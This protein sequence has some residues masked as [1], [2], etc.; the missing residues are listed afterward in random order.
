MNKQLSLI[1]FDD[2]SSSQI[3]KEN[4]KEKNTDEQNLQLH[5]SRKPFVIKTI[6]TK[7][8]DKEMAV[9]THAKKLSEYIFTITEKSPKK[10]RWSIVAKLQNTS[11]EVIENLYH[12]NFDI[13]NR[14][15]FQTKAN[16]KLHL[17]EHFAET[18]KNMQAINIHQML[19]MGK[20]IA[21]TQKL[22]SGWNRA[23]KEKSKQ[24]K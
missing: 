10:Y 14:E 5:T 1:K 3:V 17:L 19:V 23:T 22:L 6:E 8:S 24:A 4:N 13:A 9:F 21:E 16:V 2:D 7:V 11:V 18:A 20:Q 12:A 15:F